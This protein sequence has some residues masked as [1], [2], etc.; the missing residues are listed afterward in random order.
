MK[1]WQCQRHSSCG[2]LCFATA[3]IEP[4]DTALSEPCCCLLSPATDEV[5]FSID[6]DPDGGTK[7][8]STNFAQG[9]DSAAK[10]ASGQCL[11]TMRRKLTH[12]ALRDGRYG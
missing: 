1:Q 6:D 8:I 5:N 3:A 10:H 4:V 2:N 9:I 7:Q 11:Q 12:G